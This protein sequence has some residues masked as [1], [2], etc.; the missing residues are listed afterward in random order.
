[1]EKC[2]FCGEE[3]GIYAEGKPVCLECAKRCLQ[4]AEAKG[5]NDAAPEKPRQRNSRAPVIN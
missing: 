2:Y 4:V 1:M 5:A 3:A